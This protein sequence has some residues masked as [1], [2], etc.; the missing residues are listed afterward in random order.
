MRDITHYL[1]SHHLP[2]G[3]LR[4]LDGRG[5]QPSLEKLRRDGVAFTPRNDPSAVAGTVS[6]IM[7]KT[8]C[9]GTPRPIVSCTDDTATASPQQQALHEVWFR[10][11]QQPLLDK[12]RV[13]L[14]ILFDIATD[15]GD[16][17]GDRSLITFTLHQLLP[18]TEHGRVAPRYYNARHCGSIYFSHWRMFHLSIK[19]RDTTTKISW[20]LKLRFFPIILFCESV[21]MCTISGRIYATAL[22]VWNCV[23]F[24]NMT[25]ILCERVLKWFTRITTQKYRFWQR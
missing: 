1:E 18:L 8:R 25:E 7:L 21:I 15:I 10:L 22:S 23:I 12:L 2:T 5:G 16:F 14:E 9:W 3:W 4:P 11:L 13:R 24:R 17:L 19:Q 20:R 6:L